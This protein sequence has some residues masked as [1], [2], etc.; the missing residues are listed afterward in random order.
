MR[1]QQV[2][3]KNLPIG[4]GVVEACCK[5]LVTQ[6]LKRSG[7]RWQT[8]GGQSILSFR[9]LIKSDRFDQAWEIIS[10]KYKGKIEMP[11]NIVALA[12]RT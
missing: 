1:Y 12:K 2:L 8:L 10:L 4:S 5:T 9:S 7:M 11:A 6:R 3:A